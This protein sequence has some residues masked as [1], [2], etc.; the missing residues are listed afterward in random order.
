[1]K[2]TVEDALN[3]CIRQ[4]FPF[5]LHPPKTLTRLAVGLGHGEVALPHRIHP[6]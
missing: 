4:M 3:G 2:K 6:K 5:T 1:M